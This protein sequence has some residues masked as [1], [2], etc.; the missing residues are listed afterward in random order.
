MSGSD[1]FDPL[2]SLFDAPP[3]RKLRQDGPASDETALD[4]PIPGGFKTE[5]TDP[6]VS[7]VDLDADD[8]GEF[9]D[10]PHT[11]VRLKDRITQ[12]VAREQAALDAL[13]ACLEDL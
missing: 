3:V 12:E 9:D 11:D 10:E 2:A 1:G 7:D 4:A 5:F 6:R 13:A 8:F